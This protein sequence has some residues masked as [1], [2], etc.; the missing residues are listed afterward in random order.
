M[1]GK[2]KRNPRVRYEDEMEEWDLREDLGETENAYHYFCIY[3][4]MDLPLGLGAKRSIRK[5][6]EIAGVNSLSGYSSKYKWR[7]RVKAYDLHREKQRREK[8]E[9][10]LD[11]MYEKHAVLGRSLLTKAMKKL[12]ETP[13]DMLTINDVT[14]LLD[15]GFK[16]ERISRGETIEGKLRNKKL[17]AEIENLRNSSDTG[18]IQIVDDIPDSLEGV[19]DIPDDGGDG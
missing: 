14:K 12:L 10:D 19:D 4:D 5:A 3:R 1:A 8:H 13:E 17:E 15:L 9:K 11:E 18:Q 7:E 2:K 6:A 16:T